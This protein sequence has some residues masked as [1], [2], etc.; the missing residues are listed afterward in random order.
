MS[1]TLTLAR[2][3]SWLECRP[4]TAEVVGSSPIRVAN[5]EIAQ[6]QSTSLPRRGSRVR[7]SF[8]APQGHSSM[9]E[10]RSPKPSIWVRVLVPLPQQ[11]QPESSALRLFLCLRLAR[12]Y[13]ISK[14]FMQ[15]FVA[16]PFTLHLTSFSVTFKSQRKVFVGKTGN[17]NER[18]H[19]IVL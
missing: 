8:S 6:W 2:W 4:V 12:Y 1:D 15:G 7:I 11:A 16:N 10:Q 5:A 17:K 18:E 3:F 19:Q 9:V 13:F 14:Q